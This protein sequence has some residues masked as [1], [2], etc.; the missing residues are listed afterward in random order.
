M[1]PYPLQ[2]LYLLNIFISAFYHG[3]KQ[4]FRPNS[5]KINNR[6]KVILQNICVFQLS[7]DLH[8]PFYCRVMI[9]IQ[10]KHFFKTGPLSIKGS[11]TPVEVP[12]PPS[13]SVISI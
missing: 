2:L 11:G 8:V 5:L 6:Q 9:S 4:F 1:S 12:L 3:E 7:L 10:N 13:D